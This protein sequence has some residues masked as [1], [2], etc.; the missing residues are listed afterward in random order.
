LSRDEKVAVKPD[1]RFRWK[2]WLAEY[3]SVKPGQD[4]HITRGFVRIPAAGR[5]KG[6][7]YPEAATAKATSH[8]K[9][10]CG[11]ESIVKLTTFGKRYH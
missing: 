5:E 9:T 1:F 7:K 10:G 3:F 11:Y 2:H 6:C 4:H 8:C